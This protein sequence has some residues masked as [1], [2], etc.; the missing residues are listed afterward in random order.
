[1]NPVVWA[2]KLILWLVFTTLL[3]PTL[4]GNQATAALPIL[5]PIPL[6]AVSRVRQAWVEEGLKQQRCLYA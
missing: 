4:E 5:C 1:M 6:G 3:Y 2:S